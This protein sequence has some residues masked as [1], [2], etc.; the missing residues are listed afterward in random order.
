MDAAYLGELFLFFKREGSKLMFCFANIRF[1]EGR[2]LG[3]TY[4][5]GPRGGKV[6]YRLKCLLAWTLN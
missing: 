3:D 5:W 1:L 6:V 2:A 4:A